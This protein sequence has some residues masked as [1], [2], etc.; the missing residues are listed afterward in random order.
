MKRI[1]FFDMDGT[2]YDANLAYE[3]G[4]LLAWECY[5]ASIGC[6]EVKLPQLRFEEFRNYY[7]L[8]RIIVKR[9]IPNS[10]SVH[11]RLL[12]FKQLLETISGRSMPKLTL[13]LNLAYDSAV[14]ETSFEGVRNILERIAS[15]RLI[16]LITNQLCQTQ[17]QKLKYLD[18]NG[19]LI[20]WV[21]T[22]E[23]VGVE[24]PLPGIF[25]EAFRRAS[26]T[27]QD[28][29]FVGDDWQ[30]DIEPALNLGMVPVYVSRTAPYFSNN[31]DVIWISDLKDLSGAIEKV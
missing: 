11:S 10:T 3:R 16:G 30:N 14:N 8:S 13:E 31:M 15:E 27:A 29:I 1:I 21:I 7:D 19:K 12:Y 2:L 4:L 9:R 28:V 23:E 6:V 20:H 25:Q 24:K 17:L 18:P 5:D 26:C 22:S